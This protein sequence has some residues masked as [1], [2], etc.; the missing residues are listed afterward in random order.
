MKHISN[1]YDPARPD[2]K[3]TFCYTSFDYRQQ[4]KEWEE[5][6]KWVNKFQIGPPQAT[7]KHSVQE[8]VKI[9]IV[10]LYET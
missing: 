3:S 10:G 8:L 2:A 9:N 1:I 6:L 5:Y 7:E 4:K